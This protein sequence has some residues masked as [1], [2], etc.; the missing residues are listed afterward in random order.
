M[1]SL[2]RK[3]V[4]II[5]GTTTNVVPFTLAS[6]LGKHSRDE[7]M[8][9]PLNTC[10][11]S[12]QRSMAHP[13]ATRQS[14]RYCRPQYDLNRLHSSH[15]ASLGP[16][17]TMAISLE[18]IFNPHWT[19]S[20]QET[21]ASNRKAQ[22]EPNNSRQRR[23]KL[24]KE[25]SLRALTNPRIPAIGEE[26]EDDF[27]V[28]LRSPETRGKKRRA[29]EALARTSTPASTPTGAINNAISPPSAKRR[30]T[31]GC[32]SSSFNS[33][34]ES[35]VSMPP[36]PKKREALEYKASLKRRQLKKAVV[37]KPVGDGHLV[38]WLSDLRT[39]A[40]RTS[41]STVRREIHN[42][43]VRLRK[44]KVDDMGA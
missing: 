35:L 25:H 44:M 6:T 14:S 5:G 38:Q 23:Q 28:W 37:T 10:S 2:A 1:A 18:A 12:P 19:S 29:T 20:S 39:S 15:T 34:S 21:K 30:R 27:N 13:P 16:S 33:F 32:A 40:L 7:E 22:P 26:S 4:R 36:S 3:T 11:V 9:T 43:T 17:S 42:T 24:E 41:S 8:D 31:S